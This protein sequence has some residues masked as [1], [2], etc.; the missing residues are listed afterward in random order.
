MIIAKLVI[1]DISWSYVRSENVFLFMV[2]S[3]L[4]SI[5]FHF[6]K[7]PG[8]DLG[9]LKYFDEKKNDRGKN[10]LEL[11]KLWRSAIKLISSLLTLNCVNTCRISLSKII[12]GIQITIFCEENIKKVIFFNFYYILQKVGDF[13]FKA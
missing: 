6:K 2:F 8:R 9:L 13:S 3:T 4:V 12:L 10:V 7:I 11:H 5:I 1:A